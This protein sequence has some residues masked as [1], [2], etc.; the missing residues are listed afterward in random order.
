MYAFNVDSLKD[1]EENAKQNGITIKQHNIIYKLVDDIKEEMNNCLP[2][3]EVED[4]QGI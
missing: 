1:A 3:V 2:P 4:I